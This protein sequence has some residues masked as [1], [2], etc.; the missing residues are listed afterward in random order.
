MPNSSCRSPLF[1]V[2]GSMLVV[3]APRTPDAVPSVIR[4]RRA[5]ETV[6]LRLR[7]R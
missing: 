7:A 2:S 4:R 1:T 3:A 5:W 6:L